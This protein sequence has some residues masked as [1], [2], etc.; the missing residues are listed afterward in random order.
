MDRTTKGLIAIISCAAIWSTGGMLIKLV[1]WHPLVI[2]GGRSLLAALFLLAVMGIRKLRDRKAGRDMSAFE[3]PADAARARS[4]RAARWG[5]AAMNA[6]TMLIFVAATKMTTA[7]NAILL[8][9]SAPIFAAI[10]GWALIGEKPR[11]AHW[12]ALGAVCVGLLVFFKDGLGGGAFAGDALAV[13][14][15]VTFGSYSVFMRMQK[16]GR[17]EISILYSHLITAAIGLPFALV[18]PPEFSAP[19]LAGIAALGFVQIGVTS[20]LFAYAIRRVSAVQT[21]LSAVVE[22]VLNPVWVLMAT[23]ERPSPAALVGGAIILVAVTLSSVSGITDQARPGSGP[24][25]R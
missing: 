24:R 22:P 18:A 4:L 14:S 2:A 17:P 23:A 9:Y 11:K 10:L 21:M 1:P 6:A 3:P 25:R 15:G 8:Q 16:D 7:A 13:V 5:A 20:L 19:A 12:L